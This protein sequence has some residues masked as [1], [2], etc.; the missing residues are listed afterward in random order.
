MKKQELIH[1]HGLLAQV[2][3]YYQR[4]VTTEIDMSE[5]E[6]V[7]VKSTSIHKSKSDHKEAVSALGKCIIADMDSEEMQK[8][9]VS[10]D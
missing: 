5:Y 10:A 6:D 2:Q 8:T 3:N 1:I 7:G 4:E 9:P